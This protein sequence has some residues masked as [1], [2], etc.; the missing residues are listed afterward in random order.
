MKD[1]PTIP[2][3]PLVEELQLRPSTRVPRPPVNG[4]PVPV[5]FTTTFMPKERN[6]R[7]I[8]S[9]L[10]A[11]EGRFEFDEVGEPLRCTTTRFKRVV[12]EDDGA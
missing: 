8:P 11:I 10:E 7:H 9:D 3:R 4:V 12:T 5:S 2:F 1:V 6:I